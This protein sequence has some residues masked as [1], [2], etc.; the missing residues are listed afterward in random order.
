MEMLSN[1][2]RVREVSFE[3]SFFFEKILRFLRVSFFFF[4]F[5]LLLDRSRSILWGGGEGLL[6]FDGIRLILVIII[7]HYFIS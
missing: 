3:H 4:F 5:M 1:K 2:P 7:F 6:K